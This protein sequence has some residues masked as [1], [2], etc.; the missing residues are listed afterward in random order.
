[1]N[2]FE[3]ILCLA[4][5]AER[6]RHSIT[7]FCHAYYQSLIPF[8]SHCIENLPGL[9]YQIMC[10]LIAFGIK[11]CGILNISKGGNYAVTIILIWWLIATFHGQTGNMSISWNYI[12]TNAEIRLIRKCAA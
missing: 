2:I 9:T 10:F 11:C 4:Q 12:W 1:M 3:N 5:D 8:L 7:R 6:T